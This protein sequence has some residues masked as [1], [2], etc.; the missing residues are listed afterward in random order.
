M[1]EFYSR[2][3]RHPRTSKILLVMKLTT[4][5]MIIAIMQVSAVTRAQ[6][7]TLSVRNAQISTI[8]QQIRT[9]TGY[10]FAYTTKTLEGTKPVTLNVKNQELK[11]VLD[12]IFNDQPLEYNIEDKL[13]TVSTKEPSLIDKVKAAIAAIDVTGRVTDEK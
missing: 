7:V 5:I 9:Q 4:L 11:T 10:D 8:F 6:K 3:V 2:L 12:Q 1:Y 13:I